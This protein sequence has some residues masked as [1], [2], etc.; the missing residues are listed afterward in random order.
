MRKEFKKISIL[1]AAAL[2]L[3]STPSLAFADSLSGDDIPA[4][5]ESVD[6]GSGPDEDGGSDEVKLNET[7]EGSNEV[8]QENTPAEEGGDAAMPA[9][10]QE[11]APADA[12]GE[13]SVAVTDEEDQGEAPAE[14]TEDTGVLDDTGEAPAE[15]T[16]DTGIL[17][18][19]GETPTEGE[20][21]AGEEASGV[22]ILDEDESPEDA[23]LSSVSGNENDEEED[24]EGEDGEEEETDEEGE[25]EEGYAFI[26]GNIDMEMDF[27]E[28]TI[29]EIRG[30]T[31]ETQEDEEPGEVS[32]ASID[33]DSPVASSYYDSVDKYVTTPKPLEQGSTAWCWAYTAAS[34]A[35]TSM[36]KN[37][38]K[39][40]ESLEESP[41][42]VQGIV[43]TS[44]NK[45]RYDYYGETW[46]KAN[47][48][49]EFDPN[50]VGAKRDYTAFDLAT[51][52]QTTSATN[53]VSVPE[54]TA[55]KYA[56]G[57][58]I[59]TVFNFER[60]AAPSTRN[61]RNF[62]GNTDLID[63]QLESAV[64]VPNTDIDSIKRMIRDYGSAGI[65]VRLSDKGDDD[66]IV[67][68][69]SIHGI[70]HF[71]Y[72]RI[73]ENYSTNY[74]VALVAW[75]DDIS[76]E[77]FSV[78]GNRP[79]EK[80]AFLAKSMWVDR[81]NGP[82]YFWISY[83]DAAFKQHKGNYKYA[84]AY[85]FVSPKKN[86]YTYGYDGTNHYGEYYTQRVYGIFTSGHSGETTSGKVE[87]LKS[88]GV[89]IQDAGKYK[90]SIYYGYKPNA[91]GDEKNYLNLH[92]MENMTVNLNCP[93]YHTIELDEPI[94]FYKGDVIS[95][96]FERADGN[97]FNMLV[98]GFYNKNDYKDNSK[99]QHKNI[100]TIE[101]P[102][103]IDGVGKGKI[104]YHSYSH[105]EKTRLECYFAYNNGSKLVPV[106][107]NGI[108]TPE[109]SN[110]YMSLTPR[111]RLYTSVIQ[112]PTDID[113]NMLDI[114]LKKY[115]WPYNAGKEVTPDPE[116]L[117]DFTKTRPV[118]PSDRGG[119]RYSN[120][121][122]L[123]N[124]YKTTDDKLLYANNKEA[125]I[126]AVIVRG[127][128]DVFSGEI[129]VPYKIVKGD[130]N[131]SK[132]KIFGLDPQDYRSGKQFTENYSK[133]KSSILVR[134]YVTETEHY[135]TLKEGVDYKL[136]SIEEAEKGSNK[137]GGKMT[138]MIT[139][140]GSFTGTVKPKFK[141][142]KT[143]QEKPIS[144][145]DLEVKLSYTEE[146]SEGNNYV[147]RWISERMLDHGEN[148]DSTENEKTIV[149]RDGEIPELPY[150]GKR[151]LLDVDRIYDSRTG[152]ELLPGVHYKEKITYKNNK[153]CGMATIT[154]KAIKGSGYSG[155][156]T[157]RFLITPMHI[158]R[159]AK[160][161]FP[162]EVFYTGN[163]IKAKP[164]VKLYG[165]K[166]SQKDLYIDYE[167]N[168]GSSSGEATAQ[169]IVF[170][171]GKYTGYIGSGTFTIKPKSTKS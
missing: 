61:S 85:D 93:G 159:D 126:A 70:D 76:M 119:R 125:G 47:N 55:I 72:T 104:E 5:V 127:S 96:C 24:E 7:D 9:E 65:Q 26:P 146:I 32:L 37:G 4:P 67:T 112:M 20:A 105:G 33:T 62:E 118:M 29:E 46:E 111:M 74:T 158:N 128:G 139:G 50:K 162:S 124:H 78:S 48:T 166:L 39:T 156:I 36:I 81:E 69:E 73:N 171:K 103:E 114:K 152:T 109:K 143:N 157:K 12:Q 91:Q 101:E 83:D 43:E 35:E 136:G 14:N 58:L 133:V 8:M 142:R 68:S 102:F 27:T 34:L 155:K 10:D 115:I 53:Y 160:I 40:K 121:L 30:I 129:S 44:Y 77:S 170:G 92:E 52:V 100:A 94:L 97:S 123:Y 49:T 147:T 11:T 88:I 64:W 168:T 21:E 98:D 16:E 57:N 140:I 89:G 86:D 71:K 117:V 141:I 38:I 151:I 79:E 59:N 28:E 167:N 1:L 87:I 107:G 161:K 90:L 137:P 45:N 51:P 63:A 145:G 135:I 19:T 131:I 41:V 153:K 66:S 165:K 110:W 150:I 82:G 42:N 163:P 56:P 132:C 144:D 120:A 169:G 116:V 75:D 130:V 113:Q 106:S 80:G 138:V 22:V 6:N 84:V 164:T 99:N 17:D 122:L 95:V 154:I 25:E 60:W 31:S 3:T 134:Y 108:Q 54:E 149:L 2:I 23:E 18:E 13:D 148:T 15:N